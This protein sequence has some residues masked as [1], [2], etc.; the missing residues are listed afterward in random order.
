MKIFAIRDETDL[1]QKDLAYL[2]YYETPKRFYIEL[3][4][5]ADPWDTPLL[6]SSFAKEGVKSINSYWSRLW[7]Q[8]RIVPSDR[9]N[10]GQILKDN[11][12]KAYDEYELLML[13]MGRCAQDDYYLVPIT[14]NDLPKKVVK[15]FEKRIEDI[16]PLSDHALLVFFR[17]GMVRRIDLTD[18]FSSH[19]RFQILLQHPELFRHVRIQTA[20]YGI[21]WDETLSISDREL[22]GMGKRIPLSMDDFKS[23]AEERV[24]NA[25]EAA[26]LLNCSRQ[27]INDLVKAGKLHPIK[28]SEKN[29][30]FLKS[31]ILE[32]GGSKSPAA[33]NCRTPCS[34]FGAGCRL[35]MHQHPNHAIS[36]SLLSASSGTNATTSSIRQSSCSQILPN[37]F[38]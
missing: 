31:E 17:D 2:L 23:F 19:P 6:L 15:R 29:T 8:Q 28:A 26:E 7:V 16:V 20:G 14:E 33:N 22:Y 34:C 11:K 9:Q 24:V 3:P 32:Q 27:Y 18:Y 30:L 25:S 10:L 35:L 21:Q 5:D 38:K 1:S 13:G 37:T 4:E 12:L 36:L